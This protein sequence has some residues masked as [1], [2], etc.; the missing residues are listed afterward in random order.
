M[1]PPNIRQQRAANLQRVQASRGL[2][3]MGNVPRRLFY[4]PPGN[5]RRKLRFCPYSSREITL[6]YHFIFGGESVNMQV[7]LKPLERLAQ[8]ANKYEM[9]DYETV[10]NA[11]KQVFENPKY[12]FYTAFPPP[13]HVTPQDESVLTVLH[14]HGISY[15]SVRILVKSGS[16]D[17]EINTI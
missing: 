3:P 6:P 4:D 12:V 5:S 1:N 8:L 2:L 9:Q 7:T 15:E 17:F 13:H 14:Q 16:L 10:E 11:C